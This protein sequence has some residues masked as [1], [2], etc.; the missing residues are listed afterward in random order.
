V[1][2]TITSNGLV[3]QAEYVTLWVAIGSMFFGLLA[4][5]S[6][7]WGFWQLDREVSLSPVETARALAKAVL[8]SPSGDLDMNIAELL[9]VFGDRKVE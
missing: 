3:Y 1:T 2:W 6:L 9:E 5:M 7:L 4:S 8:K